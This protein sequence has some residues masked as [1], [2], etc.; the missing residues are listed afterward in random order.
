MRNM[1]RRKS[2]GLDEP[3]GKGDET[4]PE[5]A[6]GKFSNVG[7]GEND[8]DEKLRSSGIGRIL[9]GVGIDRALSVARFSFWVVDK[10]VGLAVFLWL[11]ITSPVLHGLRLVPVAAK[12]LDNW[13]TNK[14]EERRQRKATEFTG[15][16]LRLLADVHG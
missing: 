10:L 4:L 7:W 2:S 1:F 14:R 6:D 13:A 8:K 16:T 11:D 9:G 5:G 12:R 3:D 15:E